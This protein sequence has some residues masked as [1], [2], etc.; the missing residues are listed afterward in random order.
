MLSSQPEQLKCI[1]TLTGDSITHA[2]SDDHL[3]ET[4]NFLITITDFF[5]KAF[6]SFVGH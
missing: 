5:C 6:I 2:V 1:V 4:F 3:N